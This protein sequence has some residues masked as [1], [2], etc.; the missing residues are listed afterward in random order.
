MSKRII[1]GEKGSEE[2]LM[3]EIQKKD[4]LYQVDRIIQS[5]TTRIKNHAHE[6]TKINKEVD[7]LRREIRKLNAIHVHG[8]SEELDRS[9]KIDK[10]KIRINNSEKW[11]KH[12]R[13]DIRYLENQI[14]YLGGFNDKDT[15]R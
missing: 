8:L 2:A 5:N 13:K 9:I 7:G 15:Q 14:K 12:L 1:L 3:T 10:F 4:V 6:I 11:K